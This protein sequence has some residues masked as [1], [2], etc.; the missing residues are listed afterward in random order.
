MIL[1]RPIKLIVTSKRK[2]SNYPL[3]KLGKI[4]AE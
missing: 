2:N 4:F 3:E 1:N